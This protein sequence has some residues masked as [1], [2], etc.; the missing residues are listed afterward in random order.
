M[1][2]D[3]P[4]PP[5]EWASLSEPFKASNGLT[6]ETVGRL[7]DLVRIG[8]EFENALSTHAAMWVSNVVNGKE[9][10][11]R[12]VDQD[13]KLVSC[14]ELKVRGGRVEVV[15]DRAWRNGPGTPESLAAVTEYAEAVNSGA[16]EIAY[17]LT[18]FGF[19]A[20]GASPKP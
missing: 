14:G 13:G 3:K 12:V 6:V 2:N 7:D 16:V 10:I 18:E 17:D 5:Q 4:Q 1:S 19:A 9:Q 20:K 8:T 11:Y 15:Q